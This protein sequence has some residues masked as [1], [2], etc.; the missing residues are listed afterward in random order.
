MLVCHWDNVWI[1]DYPTNVTAT[2]PRVKTQLLGSYP[3]YAIA[4]NA[5]FT[6]DVEKG[7]NFCTFMNNGGGGIGTFNLPVASSTGDEFTFINTNFP[8]GNTTVVKA[9]A[10]TTIIGP[11]TQTSS[12]GT[13]TSTQAGATITLRDISSPLWVV[14]AFTGT[15]VYA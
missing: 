4:R 14:T 9:L 2:V 6:Y 1:C 8:A 13:L 11:G 10:G 15:W 5:P 12:G 7:K 3:P